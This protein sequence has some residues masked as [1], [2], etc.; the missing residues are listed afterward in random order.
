MSQENARRSPPRLTRTGARFEPLLLLR[1]RDPR[2]QQLSAR[3]DYSHC[4]HEAVSPELGRESPRRCQ[5]N[6][7]P[8][9]L[10]VS[11][12]HPSVLG[13][14]FRMPGGLL[15]EHQ[16]VYFT[17]SSRSVPPETSTARTACPLPL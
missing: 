1:S 8:L 2:A 3:H 16:C 15:T 13:S 11:L 6:H 5:R 4:R 17:S 9:L 14:G 12:S 7:D 10:P